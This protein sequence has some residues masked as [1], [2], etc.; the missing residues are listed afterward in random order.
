M[1]RIQFLQGAA[2]ALLCMAASSASLAEGYPNKPIRLIVPFPA[3]GATDLFARTLGQKMG[4]KLGTQLIIDNKPGAGGA[5]GSDQAAK[6]PADGYTLLLATTSTHSIG[7]AVVPKL[8]YDTVRDFTPIGHVG[9]APSIMLVP[10]TS[11]AK[12]VREWIDYAKKNP[13]KL[14]Y[15]SSGNGTIVQL[16]A[17]LF[18]AQAGVFVTHIPYKGTALAIPDLISGKIDVLFDSLPT[19]MPHVRD[20]RLRALGVTT[21][22]R[23]PLAPELPPIA[24]TLPGYESNTWFGFYGPKNLPADIVAR[25]NKA[26]N[27]AIA[28]PEVKDKLARL[29][30]EPAAAGTP[31][32]FAK[33]V[34]I[35]AAKWKKIVVERKITNE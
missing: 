35:D 31:E 4:E 23:S 24:D 14:N 16:T 34:A 7:P 2:V 33:M 29:G 3:G 18:K 1:K 8:P 12:T 6:A 22:K 9:D 13:G 21:L 27:E 11:P 26:A 19:G 20:G 15:A 30:I 32:Q 25:V 17:E 10:V 5:I 28:D